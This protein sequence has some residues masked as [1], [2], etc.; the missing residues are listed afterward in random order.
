[1]SHFVKQDCIDVVIAVRV[2]R[3][4]GRIVAPDVIDI[5]VRVAGD[6]TPSAENRLVAWLKAMREQAGR[7]QLP[8]GNSNVTNRATARLRSPSRAPAIGDHAEIGETRN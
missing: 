5:K 6:P 4:I 8:G 2:S 7:N 1:M 3:Q